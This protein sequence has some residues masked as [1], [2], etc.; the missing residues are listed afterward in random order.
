MSSSQSLAPR[1]YSSLETIQ[2]LLGDLVARDRQDQVLTAVREFPARKLSFVLCQAGWQVPCLRHIGPR[3]F[4]EL[5]SH[6]A[7]TAELVHDGKNVV[8]VT[9]TASGKTLCYNLRFWMQCWEIPT[10]AH[11]TCFRPKP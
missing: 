10:F 6:Q 5:Y 4:E 11:C 2:K 8:V 7:A 3:E 9:P 1:P